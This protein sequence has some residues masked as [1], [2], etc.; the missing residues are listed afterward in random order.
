MWQVFRKIMCWKKIGV[1]ISS[2]VRLSVFFFQ[3]HFKIWIKIQFL[4]RNSL[5]VRPDSCLVDNSRWKFTMCSPW[6]R[7]DRLREK[8]MMSFCKR[9]SELP[10]VSCFCFLKCS[11]YQSPTL[12]TFLA[13]DDPIFLSLVEMWIGH[14][15]S[16]PRNEIWDGNQCVVHILGNVCNTCICVKVGKRRSIDISNSM[17]N[18]GSYIAPHHKASRS[19]SAWFTKQA[20]A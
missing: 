10:G 13:T 1:G 14:R 15:L 17:E 11:H 18:L 20:A 3:A 5:W 19:E 12:T 16:F 9:G 2:M 4:G 6:K 8:T 7:R